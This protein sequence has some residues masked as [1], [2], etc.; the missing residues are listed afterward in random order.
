MP[1]GSKFRTH[2]TARAPLRR[3]TYRSLGA[4]LGRLAIG[5]GLVVAT[6]LI[7]EPALARDTGPPIGTGLFIGTEEPPTAPYRQGAPTGSLTMNV[8]ADGCR[9]PATL[10][11]DLQILGRN[12]RAP[13]ACSETA[14][15]V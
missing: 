11:G 10:D 7:L 3:V 4:L 8:T 9:N 12:V 13:R 1:G 6:V 5:V 2:R 15:Q 14:N